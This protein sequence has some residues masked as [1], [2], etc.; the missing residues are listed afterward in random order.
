MMI[1]SKINT[2]PPTEIPIIAAS[3]NVW[4]VGDVVDDV[5]VEIDDELVVLVV[6]V[7]DA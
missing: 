4:L 7:P 2:D 5:D 6:V 3:L 1:T